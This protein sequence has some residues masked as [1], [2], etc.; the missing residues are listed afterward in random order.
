[1]S[2]FLYSLISIVSFAPFVAFWV[3]IARKFRKL[4]AH[5]DDLEALARD[6]RPS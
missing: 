5:I 3:W 1:M 4:H 6:G 2:G